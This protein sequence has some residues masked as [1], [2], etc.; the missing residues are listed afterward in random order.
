V[1]FNGTNWSCTGTEFLQHASEF[2]AGTHFPFKQQSAAS[3][4]DVPA[5][6]HSNGL[7]S[8]TTTIRL[9]AMW[10]ARR[11]QLRVASDAPALISRPIRGEACD[12]IRDFRQNILDRFGFRV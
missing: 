7:R 10:R 3:P 2:V 9:T 12:A 5:A 4:R 8:R 1:D 11:I 6:K